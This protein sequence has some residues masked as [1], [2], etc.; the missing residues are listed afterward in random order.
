[1]TSL[2]DVNVLLALAWPNHV[3][4]ERAHRW[5]RSIEGQRWATCPVTQS[6][7]VRV[8]CNRKALTYARAPLEAVALLRAIVALPGHQFWADDFDLAGAEWIL[9]LPLVGHLQITDLR[10]VALARSNDGKVITFDRGVRSLVP[11]GEDAAK[12][13]E[14][15]DA[16]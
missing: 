2:L 14:V 5:F 11:R 6:G 12:H 7:F 16:T 1:V 15:L 9:E 4:H 8:S 13:V 3:H 10:L